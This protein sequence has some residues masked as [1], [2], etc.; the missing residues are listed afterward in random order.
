[1]DDATAIQQKEYA[2]AL[3]VVLTL[4]IPQVIDKLEEILR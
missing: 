2:M 4:Q 1:V 3:S